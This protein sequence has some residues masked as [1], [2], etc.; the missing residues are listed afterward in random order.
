MHGTLK[1]REDVVIY[2]ADSWVEGEGTYKNNVFIHVEFD[3]EDELRTVY[4]NL[5]TDGTVNMPVDRTFWGAIYGDLIDKFGI[6]WG[7]HYQLPE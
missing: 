1:I 2:L 3:S 4:D 6:G 5:S 7:L